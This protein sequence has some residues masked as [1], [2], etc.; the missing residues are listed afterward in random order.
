MV[1]KSQSL[2]QQTPHNKY[3][4]QTNNSVFTVC[5]LV[6]TSA[7]LLQAVGN[8]LRVIEVDNC[9]TKVTILSLNFL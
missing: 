4:C 8:S 3:H 2:T 7:A 1:D 5:K 9:C 6:M